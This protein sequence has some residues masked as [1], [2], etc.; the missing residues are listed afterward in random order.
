MEIEVHMFVKK[1]RSSGRTS[2]DGDRVQDSI[3]CIGCWSNQTTARRQTRRDGRIDAQR[4]GHRIYV[5]TYVYI[6]L[7]S[8]FLI[9]RLLREAEG[10]HGARGPKGETE[11][12]F[13]KEARFGFILWQFF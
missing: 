3:E 7:S 13:K 6:F 5:Y 12:E 10:M 2:G 11:H 4:Q 9:S 1:S 8:A